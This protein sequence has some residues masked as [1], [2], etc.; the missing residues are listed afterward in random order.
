M[1]AWV[2]HSS[3]I[4]MLAVAPAYSA[5]RVHFADGGVLEA[6]SCSIESGVATVTLPDGGSL[7]FPAA[8]IARVEAVAA[9][10][11]APPAAPLIEHP[12]VHP[13]APQAVPVVVP[14]PPAGTPVA[15]QA[16]P[17][18]E[19][20]LESLIREAAQRHNLEMDLL[21][22][23]IAV[24]SG[25]RPKAVSPKGAQGLMQLMPGTA[26][27]LA[28]TDPFDPAQ[29]INAGARYL[30]QLIDQ[31]QGSY[32]RALAAYNA[33]AR[34]ASQ[35]GGLPPYR[36]TISYIHRVLENYARPQPIPPLAT[37]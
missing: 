21:A 24:E 27:D 26:R 30:R 34:R 32:W 4:L 22:A 9:A 6:A 7:A 11:A 13:P 14:E 5:V 33:G 10:Q 17:P 19:Q 18:S 29:N 23:V 2:V 20:T 35:Y 3:V 37:R 1:R 31:H 15:A 16:A 8:R 25:F 12:P 28:V 36:E